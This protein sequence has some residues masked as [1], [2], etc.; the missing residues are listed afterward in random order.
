MYICWCIINS[1]CS[2][3]FFRLRITV[4]M[5]MIGNFV[6]RL[7]LSITSVCSLPYH[8]KGAPLYQQ[9]NDSTWP[10][11]MLLIYGC[12]CTCACMFVYIVSV[13]L[14]VR[15]CVCVRVCVCER[16]CVCVRVR[17]C[18]CEYV[19]AGPRFRICVCVWVLIEW[20]VYST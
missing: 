13:F 11:S 4:T 9:I 8:V 20:H 16:A 5:L 12:L 7:V 15:L 14:S 19:F 10:V 18:E 17:V 6:N 3:G 1:N 2:I